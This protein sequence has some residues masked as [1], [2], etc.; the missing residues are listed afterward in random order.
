MKFYYLK[1]LTLLSF[2]LISITANAHDFEAK[3]SDG[4]TIYYNITSSTDKTCAVTYSS[5]YYSGSIVIPET[6]IYNGTSYSVTSIG[7]YAF[8]D[9]R[10]LTSIIIPNSVTSIGNY[11]FD[12]CIGLTSITIPNSVTSIGDAA[13][14]NC[15]GLTSIIIPNSV[16]SIGN[17]A[18]D[19][20]IGLTS[21]TIPNS[22]TSIGNWAFKDC[23]GLTSITIPNSVTSIGNYAF[24]ECI[25]L[26]SIIIP[27]S[28]TSIGDAAFS[29]CSGLTSIIIESGNTVYDSRNNCNAI[30]KTTS[31]TLIAGCKNTIIPNTVTSI[32]SCAFKGCTGLIS[33]TIP[34][35]VTGIGSVAFYG[36]KSLA[37]CV[38]GNSV[39]TIDYSAFGSCK[40]LT[41]INIPNSV[42]SISYDV[43]ENCSSLAS[44]TIPNSVTSIGNRAFSGCISL[45]ELRI[46]DGKS[47]LSLG[48]NSYNSNLTGEGL[49]YDCPLETLY[50]GRNIKYTDNSTAPYRYY[51]ERY[52]YSAFYNKTILK[53][54]VIGSSVTEIGNKAFGNCTGL[55]SVKSLN[56][57]PPTCGTDVFKG[58]DYSVATL[59]VPKGSFNRYL[60]AN[61]WGD[62]WNIEEVDFSGIEVTLTDSSEVKPTE[63]YNLQGVRVEN[64]ERGL[65]IKR[66][67]G[68]TSKVIL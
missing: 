3:N 26:T 15:R 67:G 5:S 28:V 54:I 6:V 45:K 21:I 63:Y 59:T 41:D 39:T 35:S 11:A 56:P 53:S 51:P 36:C 14:S 49:F 48:F 2:L 7:N 46:E 44:I 42:T 18:F 58:I 8:S 25:G 32:G 50:L 17:Y 65:Y 16:T 31:K 4:V 10:G 62:F 66:Q 20:C 9:C 33:I 24:D 38:V 68:K 34:N 61:V 27:N 43:F 52:G 19:E 23:S 12:E 57:T 60:N 47:T 64:P 13:F 55:T 30:I 1:A 29:N 22:V 37:T 40:S